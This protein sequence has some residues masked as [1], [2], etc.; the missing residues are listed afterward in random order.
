[1]SPKIKELFIIILIYSLKPTSKQAGISYSKLTEYLWPD[2]PDYRQKNNRSVSVFKL[3]KILSDFPFIELVQSK[4]YLFFK[5][6]NSVYSDFGE[7]NLLM[8]NYLQN[9]NT[10][11]EIE[12]NKFCNIIN[13]GS[14]LTNINYDWL[15]PIKIEIHEEIIEILLK[16]CEL[17]LKLSK[18]KELI[19]LSNLIMMFD[20]LSPE[21]LRYK[22]IA[23]KMLGKFSLAKQNYE[24]FCKEYLRIYGE[25]FK[26]GF[27]ELI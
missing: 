9:D 19:E 2:I 22:C 16:K 11:S 1:M 24:H 15:D 27:N 21:A 14:F 18:H 3:R 12:F 8:K 4:N 13:E 25:E 5:N 23:L 20:Q 10:L 6:C 26:V 17:I 7:L